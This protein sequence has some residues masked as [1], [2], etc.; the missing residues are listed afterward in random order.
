[1]PAEK[2]KLSERMV[3]FNRQMDCWLA[4]HAEIITTDAERRLARG[5]A[6]AAWNAALD[7]AA[8]R[9]NDRED[10]TR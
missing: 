9:V 4:F 7:W 8:R 5:A 6:A 1:M 3:A 10:V 2:R